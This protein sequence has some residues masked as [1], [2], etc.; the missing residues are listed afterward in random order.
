MAQIIKSGDNVTVF[1]S[2]KY[3]NLILVE[4]LQSF[5][6]YPAFCLLP[7][8]KFIDESLKTDRSRDKIGCMEEF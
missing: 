1:L 6:Q 8:I 7:S 4:Q 5:T 3:M 2:L